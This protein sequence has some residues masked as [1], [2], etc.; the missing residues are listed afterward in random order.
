[1]T[2]LGWKGA[3][4]TRAMALDQRGLDGD[5]GDGDADADAGGAAPPGEA[6]TEGDGMLPRALDALSFRVKGLYFGF[7]I[8]L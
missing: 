1:M 7:G 4:G 8:Y 2:P 3:G 6:R 5:D